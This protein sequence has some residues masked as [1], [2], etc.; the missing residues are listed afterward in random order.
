MGGEISVNATVKVCVQTIY[1]KSAKIRQFSAQS[2]FATAIKGST[3]LQPEIHNGFNLRRVLY[4][5]T[6]VAS[7]LKIKVHIVLPRAALNFFITSVR[8]S[9]IVY[10]G[11]KFDPFFKNIYANLRLKIIRNGSPHRFE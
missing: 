5:F 1:K 8:K 7:L 9:S 11:A 10:N 6:S 2:G 3:I 4:L